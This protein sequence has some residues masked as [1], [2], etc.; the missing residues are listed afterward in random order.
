MRGDLMRCR[1]CPYEI[2]DLTLRTE[3]YNWY[4]VNNKMTEEEM[5]LI[6]ER[7]N[8]QEGRKYP[9]SNQIVVCGFF[10]TDEEWNNFVNNNLDKIK[11][12]KKDRVIFANKEQWY[13]F[14]YINYSQRGYRFYKI[15]VSR[16]VNREL[17][18]NC[19]YPYCS[20]YCKEIEWI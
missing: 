18:L 4:I 9:C 16:N 19:I 3:M 8:K 10:S 6:S 5:K 13:H 17:F 1:N 20:L 15:K 12:R 14:D 11:T 7:I 2:E